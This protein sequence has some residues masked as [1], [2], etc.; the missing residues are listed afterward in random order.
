MKEKE[1]RKHL[2][3]RGLK[4]TEEKV[5]AWKVF[6]PVR[7]SNVHSLANLIGQIQAIFPTATILRSFNLTGSV[8][9]LF[10]LKADSK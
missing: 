1:I 7:D 8:G 3:I 2:E 9:I 6:M 10:T 4:V 5:T